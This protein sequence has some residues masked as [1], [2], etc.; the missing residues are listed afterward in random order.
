MNENVQ[1]GHHSVGDLGTD[2]V[3]E[4]HESEQQKFSG[5]SDVRAF[6]LLLMSLNMRMPMLIYGCP[7]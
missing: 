5:K 4:A 2:A 1:N 6:K 3:S 7:V